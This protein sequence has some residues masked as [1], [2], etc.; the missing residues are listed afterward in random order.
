[1]MTADGSTSRAFT[2]DQVTSE[3]PTI[4][5][6]H[7]AKST[8]YKVCGPTALTSNKVALQ[9]VAVRVEGENGSSLN[10]WALLDTG[11]EESFIAKPTTDIL[12]LKV[13][14]FESLAV[15]TL[16]GESTVCVGKVDLAI[17]PMEGPEGPRIQIKD[18]K[19]VENLNVNLS[20]P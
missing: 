4:S 3:T 9:V 13:T 7:F 18:V 17:L 2:C 20:R 15:C 11:T 1:M 16:T 8:S 6:V 19:L 5:M 10:T 12:K 14:S